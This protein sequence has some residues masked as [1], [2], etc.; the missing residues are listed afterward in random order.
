MYT[1]PMELFTTLVLF[2]TSLVFSVFLISKGVLGMK[3][4]IKEIKEGNN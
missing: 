2:T 3:K 1:N 4:S